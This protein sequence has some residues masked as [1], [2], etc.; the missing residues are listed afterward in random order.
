MVC[1]LCRSHKQQFF[2]AIDGPFAAT[3]ALVSAGIWFNA[4]DFNAA[5]DTEAGIIQAIGS[6]MTGV[7]DCFWCYVWMQFH[8]APSPGC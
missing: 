5:L 4:F 6:P 1:P 7:Q 3:L 2:R 8:F